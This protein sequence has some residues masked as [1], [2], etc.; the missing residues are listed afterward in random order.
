[1]QVLE[2]PLDTHP[3]FIASQFH[4]ELTSRPLR[5]QP[6]RSPTLSCVISEVSIQRVSTSAERCVA[7]CSTAFSI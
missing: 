3:F 7:Q 1:M 5:P 4:P 2:L 6:M